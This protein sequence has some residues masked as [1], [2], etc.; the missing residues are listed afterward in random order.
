MQVKIRNPKSETNNKH[1]YQN[2]KQTADNT[3]LRFFKKLCRDGQINIV[4][5]PRILGR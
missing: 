3:C 1:E 5:P 2:Y 4:L